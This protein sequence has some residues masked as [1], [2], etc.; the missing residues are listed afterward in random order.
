MP[1]KSTKYGNRGS[2]SFQPGDV[3]GK[4][5][6]YSYNCL[7]GSSPGLPGMEATGGTVGYTTETN[8]QVYKVHKFESSGSF[9]VDSA[10]NNPVQPDEVEYL[11]VAG[12]GGGGVNLAGAGGA[13]GFRTNNP[14]TPNSAPD[15]TST[16]DGTYV[17]PTYPV[18]PGSYTVTVGGGG[19]S[20]TTGS[21]SAFYP[22]GAPTP[23]APY[24]L[25][26]GGGHGG[27][28]SGGLSGEAGGSGGGGSGYG[29]SSSPPNRQSGGASDTDAAHPLRQGYAGGL[30]GWYPAGYGGGGGGGAARQGYDGSNTAT[31]TTTGTWPDS[32]GG[33]GGDGILSPLIPSPPTVNSGR[34]YYFAGGGGGGCYQPAMVGGTGGLGGGGGGGAKTGG[35]G[36]EGSTGGLN[37][38][39]DGG[40]GPTG[41]VG[42]AGGQYTGGGGGGG[43][44]PNK[45]GG[46]GGS[47]YVAIRYKIIPSQI[48]QGLLTK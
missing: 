12:G 46:A 8:G 29:T 17:A 33:K 11:V 42:G 34:G 35:T 1:A 45:A 10:S 43:S 7:E 22:A 15:A 13:G 44:H 14:Y 38:G 47:G 4:K 48:T 18:S 28:D 6:N 30:G 41:G 9:V 36:G 25:A 20:A 24:V 23:S 31:P 16:P 26:D 39:S 32:T 2:T 19:A 3:S 37:D 27:G 21:D 40:D 5:I